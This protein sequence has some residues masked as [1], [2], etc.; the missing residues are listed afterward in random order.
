MKLHPGKDV[1]LGSIFDSGT[2]DDDPELLLRSVS[3]RFD[4]P[5]GRTVGELCSR[6]EC[7]IYSTRPQLSL[8][9]FGEFSKRP[10]LSPEDDKKRPTTQAAS[11]I[12]RYNLRPEERPQGRAG[13]EIQPSARLGRRPSTSLILTELS[14]NSRV[15]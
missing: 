2:L 1:Q 8:E 10:Q 12:S 3:H 15:F 4:K 13:R 14:A 6:P 7:G 5:P 11:L 9:T